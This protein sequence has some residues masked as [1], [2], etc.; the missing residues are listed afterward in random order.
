MMSEDSTAMFGA[1]ISG[2]E[3]TI[4]V[5]DTCSMLAAS[6][7]HTSADRFRLLLGTSR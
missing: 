6:G 5:H 2:R 3:G 7:E 1:K 4:V